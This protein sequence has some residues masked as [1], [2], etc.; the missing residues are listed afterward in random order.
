MN[1]ISIRW[2]HQYRYKN[3]EISINFQNKFKKLDFDLA[4]YAFKSFKHLRNLEELYIKYTS[5]NSDYSLF[6]HLVNLQK[7]E[8]YKLS[9]E[10]D[11][12]LNNLFQTFNQYNQNLISLEI[13]KFELENKLY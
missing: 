12:A 10:N 9:Q 5:Y 7:L 3:K 13:N 1:K 8:I 6:K 2:L 4:L 11:D